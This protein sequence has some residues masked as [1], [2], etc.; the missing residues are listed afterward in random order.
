M[1][2][3]EVRKKRI[4]EYI[5]RNGVNTGFAGMT[6]D[7]VARGVGMG[8]ATVYKLFS[9]KEELLC[10]SV[11]YLAGEI[12]AGIQGV[13]SKDLPAIEKLESFL[14]LVAG[15]LAA[16]KPESMMQLE[17]TMPE[18]YARIEEKRQRIVFVNLKALLDEGKQSGLY[19]PAM[20]TLLVTHMVI[21]A[22]R[23]ITQERVLSTLHYSFDQLFR[24]VISVILKGCLSQSGREQL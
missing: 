18:I 24:A 7:D 12:E 23:Q 19:D 11:D 15:K 22:M 20:D 14:E 5:I 17:R 2:T 4:Y 13:L 21:G 10:S 3:D 8:K 9:S 16:I 6:M 1:L